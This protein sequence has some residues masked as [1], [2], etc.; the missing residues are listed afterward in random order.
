MRDGTQVTSKTIIR[1]FLSAVLYAASITGKLPALVASAVAQAPSLALSGIVTSPAGEPMEGVLVSTQREGTPVTITVVSDAT[2][3]FAFPATR[4]H[5]GKYHLAVRAVGFELATPASVDIATGAETHAALQL[6]AARDTAAQLSNTEWLSSW[7]GTNEQKRPLI[8][9]MSCHT[10]ERIARSKLGA[11]ELHPLLARMSQY[12]NNTTPAK[13]QSRTVPRPVHEDTVRRLAD[14]LAGINASKGPWSYPLHTLAR[15]KGRATRVIVT[16]YE[17]PRATIAPHDVRTDN[18][19]VVW[20]SNFVENSLGRFDPRT[21]EHREFRTPIIKPGAAEGA[22][23]LEPDPDGNWWLSSMFQSGL[24]LFDV[25]TESFRHWP[26]P[27]ELDHDAAQQSLLMPW[28]RTVDGRVWTNDVQRQL[29]LA[30]DTATGRYDRI[31]PFRALPKGRPHAPYG[32]V[33]DAA[34]NLF[35]M[36][37]AGE[38]LGRV[39]ARTLGV[40]LYPTPTPQSRPR[41][42]MIDAGG[43]IWFAEFA[44]DK[45]GMFDSVREEFREWNVPTPHTHPYDVYRDA[46]GDVWTGSMASNRIGRF[47]PETGAWVEY[48]LPRPTNIRRIHVDDRT[49]PPTL[50]AGS[51]HGASIIKLEPLD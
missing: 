33:A 24:Y 42:T 7:P 32:M 3:R 34:N 2:G 36:D 49:T 15:P 51:N 11:A 20:Y 19:G 50:W 47:N 39:D 4:L 9:C 46:R 23:A 25:K 40:T 17:L 10:L 12:A 45:I 48:L 6:A 18:I 44:A 26:L 8:E 37:F 13:V 1:C 14:Y 43:L 28:R 21:A 27:P 35:F 29:I 22:L 38:S 30:L 41:R 31:D 5:P 16:E